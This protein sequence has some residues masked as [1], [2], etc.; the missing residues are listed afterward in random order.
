MIMKKKT[1]VKIT[2]L[3]ALTVVV[4][5]AITV[6]FV[7]AKDNV[8]ISNAWVP[9]APPK[10]KIMAGYLTIKN[11]TDDTIEVTG[12]SSPEFSHVMIHETIVKD[13]VSTMEMRDKLILAA[14]EEVDFKQGGLH[15]MLM[16]KTKVFKQGDLVHLKFTTSKGIISITA[17]VKNPVLVG[18]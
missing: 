8:E 18:Q 15:L 16:Y 2:L 1:A 17:P 13:G 5:Y 6:M 7:E 10:A 11:P 12:V 4:M 14:G 9:L 3:G